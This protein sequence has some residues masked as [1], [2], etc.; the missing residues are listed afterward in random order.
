M[1]Q[2]LKTRKKRVVKCSKLIVFA[3]QWDWWEVW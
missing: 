3:I 2:I 1:L